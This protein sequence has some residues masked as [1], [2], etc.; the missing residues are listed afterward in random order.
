MTSEN[1]TILSAIDAVCERITDVDGDIS[2]KYLVAWRGERGDALCVVAPSTTQEIQD[3]ISV[4]RRY[5]LR[6][7]PQGARTGLVGASVPVVSDKDSS[8]IVSL[9]RFRARCEYNETEQTVTVD[10][11]FHLS[12]VNEHLAEYGMCVPVNV[13]SDPMVGAMVATNI[14]GSRVVKYGDMR[15]L[16]AGIEVVTADK[17][18]SV[19][20]TLSRPRKDNSSLNFTQLFVG[21][22]GTCGIVTAATIRVVPVIHNT[23]TV[24]LS[25]VSGADISQLVHILEQGSGDTLLACELIS[26]EAITALMDS[27]E[28]QHSKDVIPFGD[29]DGDLVFVEWG[30][31]HAELDINA[32]AEKVVANVIE[33]SLADD[34]QFVPTDTSWQLRHRVSESVQKSGTLIG[35]DISVTRDKFSELRTRCRQ[36]V[37]DTHPEYRVCDFGHVGDGGV[38]M[39][40]V[41]PSTHDI[42]SEEIRT[43]RSDIAAIATSLGGSFSAEHGLG[44]FNAYLY[45]KYAETTTRRLSSDFKSSCD[46]DGLLGHSSINL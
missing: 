25:L 36:Y 34:A 20:S 39:N 14:A 30:S 45:E 1:A 2:E 29:R 37:A 15:Y 18:A 9:E 23:Q 8:V 28:Q 44:S 11:G 3:L 38:H 22:F 42:S 46:P 17:D 31:E 27:D 35:C 13:S 6:L 16:C 5:H 41:V 32:M 43:I 40:I 19:Y 10:A 21:S 7:V 24:W 33:S 26:R 12:E 4:A